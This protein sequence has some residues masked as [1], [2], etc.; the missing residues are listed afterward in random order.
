MGSKS[1]GRGRTPQ[2]A[3]RRRSDF[4][5]VSTLAVGGFMS[6]MHEATPVS[7][8][9]F[10]LEVQPVTLLIAFNEHAEETKEKLQVLLRLRQGERVDGEVTCL[11][12]DVQVRAAEDRRKRLEAA[13]NV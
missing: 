12:P 4:S 6:E 5:P 2:P 10:F 1:V 9:A 11:L 3:F 13:A 7:Q 8:P